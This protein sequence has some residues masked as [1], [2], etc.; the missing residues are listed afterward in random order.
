MALDSQAQLNLI[1][2]L[3]QG[4]GRI[5]RIIISWKRGRI[6]VI[7]NPIAFLLYCTVPLEQFLRFDASLLSPA[8]AFTPEDRCEYSFD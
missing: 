5:P 8:S 3:R 1:S 2:N 6:Q 7:V 4:V